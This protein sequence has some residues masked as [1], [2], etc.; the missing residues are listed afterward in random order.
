ME[1]EFTSGLKV[2]HTYD[3]VYEEIPD[4]CNEGGDTYPKTHYDFTNRAFAEAKE[5]ELQFDHPI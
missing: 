4:Y 2:M 5:E 1:T 3:D